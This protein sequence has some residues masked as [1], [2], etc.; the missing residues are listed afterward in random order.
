[1]T[2]AFE[3]LGPALEELVLDTQHGEPNRPVHLTAPTRNA[4]GCP[5]HSSVMEIYDQHF[6]EEKNPLLT[7]LAFMGLDE[8]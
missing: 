3:K 7:A 2:T 8:A 1:M 6:P 5:L 4:L